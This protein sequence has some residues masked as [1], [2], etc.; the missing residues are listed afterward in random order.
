M[1]N[2]VL[3]M[4]SSFLA[5]RSKCNLPQLYG[6][7]SVMPAYFG[8]PPGFMLGLMSLL[9]SMNVA[10]RFISSLPCRPRCTDWTS[11]HMVPRISSRTILRDYDW[12]HLH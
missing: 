3:S 7:D 11:S 4:L 6:L 10:D 1:P 9:Q 2:I 5:Y 8:N 12:R